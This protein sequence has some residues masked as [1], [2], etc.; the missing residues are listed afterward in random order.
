MN[1]GRIVKVEEI[2]TTSTFKR[3][4]VRLQCVL[5][6]HIVDGTMWE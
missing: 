6:N 3:Q 4:S 5:S 2:V 1:A